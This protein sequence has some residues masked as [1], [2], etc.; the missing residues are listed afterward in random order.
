MCIRDSVV[1]IAGVESVTGTNMLVVMQRRAMWALDRESGEWNG[2]L[3]G[4][5]TPFP[6]GLVRAPTLSESGSRAY[7]VDQESLVTFDFVVGDEGALEILAT[8]QPISFDSPFSDSEPTDDEAVVDILH[9][10]DDIVFISDG[11]NTWS[12]PAPPR[13]GE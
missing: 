7:A 4:I 12:L 3:T 5:R 10:D 9:A 11:S 2:P 6:G 13:A 8:I 1:T